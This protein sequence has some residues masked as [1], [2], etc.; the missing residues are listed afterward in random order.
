MATTLNTSG[1]TMGSSTMTVSGSAPSF[2]ARAWAQINGGGVPFIN[3]SGNVTSVTSFGT[4]DY[5]ANFTTAMPDTN[6]AICGSGSASPSG[7]YGFRVSLVATTS[8]RF[9]T[10][11]AS[12]VNSSQASVVVFR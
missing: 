9:Q 2:P 12:L 7:A 1:I 10:S 11:T 3:A 5:R 6:F 8:V 4:G